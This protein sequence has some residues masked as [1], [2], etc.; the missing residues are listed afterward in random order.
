MMRV[1]I[2]AVL[3]ESLRR[4][5]A[6]ARAE[7]AAAQRESGRRLEPWQER[8]LANGRAAWRRPT[9][10]IVP[11][12]RMATARWDWPAMD[13]LDEQAEA[14]RRAKTARRAARRLRGL[15]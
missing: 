13:A 9:F 11:T 5:F 15:S 1:A 14:R 6:A 3:P 2:T 12:L 4:E 7:L 10:A 8:D